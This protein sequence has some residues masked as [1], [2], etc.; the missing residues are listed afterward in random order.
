[1]HFSSALFC[2]AAYNA[3][4]TIVARVW[5]RLGREL[6]IQNHSIR[7]TIKACKSRG[8]ATNF[9]SEEYILKVVFCV[10]SLHTFHL[11]IM[12]FK[13]AVEIPILFFCFNLFYKH[14]ISPFLSQD[15]YRFFLFYK[16]TNARFASTV[17]V[18]MIVRTDLIRITD[19]TISNQQNRK[20]ALNLP[21]SSWELRFMFHWSAL[22]SRMN[23][24]RA[25]ACLCV[26]KPFASKPVLSIT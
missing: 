12:H 9:S 6:D 10:V 13:V 19:A 8:F 16:S 24:M 7:Q 15:K 11:L 18:D 2:S 5:S 3:C 22:W 20:K 25:R 26:I 21:F 14:T 23:C 17:L 4:W 1:M